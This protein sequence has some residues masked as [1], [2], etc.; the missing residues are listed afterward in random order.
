MSF[1]APG[2]KRI[3][4][5]P[6]YLDSLNRPNVHLNW[7]G[8]ER[9]VDN[10]IKLRTGEVIPL[11]VIIFATG[12]SVV[13]SFSSSFLN[14]V[15]TNAFNQIPEELHVRGSKGVTVME[16]F[17]AQG[18]PTAYLG[19][20]APGKLAGSEDIANATRAFPRVES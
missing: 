3:I 13:G 7:D 18:G 6:G 14:K 20:S 8:I 10:G 11:D 9:I 2:C 4:V 17:E 12:F 15:V 16:Y 19:C 5:D 1:A